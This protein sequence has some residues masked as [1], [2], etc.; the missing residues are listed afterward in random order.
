M[1][2]EEQPGWRQNRITSHQIP[3][4]HLTKKKITHSLHLLILKEHTIQSENIT[5]YDETNSYK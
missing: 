5:F 1:T 2:T 3:R 4:N